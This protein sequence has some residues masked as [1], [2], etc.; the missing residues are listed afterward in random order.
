MIEIFERHRAKLQ[1]V[2]GMRITRA[3]GNARRD[4]INPRE[5]DK[6]ITNQR[7]TRADTSNIHRENPR[8]P[9]GASSKDKEDLP[10]TL[11]GKRANS[12][13]VKRKKVP[14]IPI[15]KLSPFPATLENIVDKQSNLASKYTPYIQSLKLKSKAPGHQS[16]GTSYSFSTTSK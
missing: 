2:A 13:P 11:K 15:R 4:L 8:L 1:K 9:S 14:E 12:V 7:E 10:S 6:Q 3:P 16:T 5:E